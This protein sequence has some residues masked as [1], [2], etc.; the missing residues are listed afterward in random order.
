MS[1]DDR[2]I[3]QRNSFSLTLRRQIERFHFRASR[4]LTSPLY[5]NTRFD[6]KSIEWL[7][8]ICAEASAADCMID[9]VV[10]TTTYSRLFCLRIFVSASYASPTRWCLSAQ[11]TV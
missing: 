1:N 6:G 8:L 11:S 9:M 4:L 5:I 10:T 3:A 2:N 7:Q